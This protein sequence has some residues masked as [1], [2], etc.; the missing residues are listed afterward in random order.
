MPSVTS[1]SKKDVKRGQMTRAGSANVNLDADDYKG[2]PPLMRAFLKTIRLLEDAIEYL[3]FSSPEDDKVKKS[4]VYQ[5][6]LK[7]RQRMR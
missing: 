7:F 4:P 6:A 2:E 3:S 1:S 5:E